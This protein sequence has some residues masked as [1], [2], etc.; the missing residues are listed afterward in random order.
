LARIAALSTGGAV[1]EVSCFGFVWHDKVTSKKN[2]R[3]VRSIV[4]SVYRYTLASFFGKT[5]IS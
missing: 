5:H 1:A 3:E 2:T 4:G